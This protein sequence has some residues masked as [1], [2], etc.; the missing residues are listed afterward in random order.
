MHYY[1]D[2]TGDEH[3]HDDVTLVT[4]QITRL[5][6]SRGYPEDLDIRWRL[7]CCQ[8]DG[9]CFYGTLD[10]GTLTGLLSRLLSDDPVALDVLLPLAACGDLSVALQPNGYG[11]HYTHANCISICTGGYD[12]EDV[13]TEQAVARFEAALRD[14][15]ESVCDQ[16]EQDGYTLLLDAFN[17][18]HGERIL[19]RRASRHFEVCVGA[20]PSDYISLYTSTQEAD[21]M[22][23]ALV[24]GEARLAGLHLSVTERE[25][26][27]VLSESRDTRFIPAGQPV[28]QWLS[29]D[30][31]HD[32]VTEARE[33]VA[34]RLAWYH[35]FQPDA[36]HR[37]A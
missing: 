9:V 8:G 6:T 3:D 14:D 2:V 36:A 35:S 13:L 37:A 21:V 24:R 22:L 11:H 23:D 10:G 15:I 32:L 4:R 31:L 29:R 30:C 16:A 19:Y 20:Q 33:A 5:L 34:D 17:P 7:S 25:T 27:Y 12:G 1:A 28:W 18:D 26:G